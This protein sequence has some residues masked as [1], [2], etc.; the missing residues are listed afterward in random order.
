MNRLQTMN[1]IKTNSIKSE[2][3]EKEQIHE[4]IVSPEKSTDKDGLYYSN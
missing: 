3:E 1:E 4:V 2:E